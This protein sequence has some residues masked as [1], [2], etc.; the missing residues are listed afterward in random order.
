MF[1]LS[2]A[3]VSKE[4][5]EARYKGKNFVEGSEKNG[6]Q[7]LFFSYIYCILAKKD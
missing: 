4:S 1:T 3:K 7:F 2:F 6:V 5:L